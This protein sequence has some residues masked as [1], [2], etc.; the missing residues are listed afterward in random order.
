[1]SKTIFSIDVE[2]SS[3][4]PFKGN[5]LSVGIVAIDFDSLEIGNSEYWELSYPDSAKLDSP[6]TYEWWEQQN[7]HAF[8][9]A[10]GHREC[11]SEPNDVAQKLSDFVCG[12]SDVWDDRIFAAN[13]STFDFGWVSKLLSGAGLNEVFHY[14]T[15]CIRSIAFGIYGGDWGGGRKDSGEWNIPEI[16]HHAYYDALA[17]GKD[18]IKLLQEI[19]T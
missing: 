10:W 9:A 6:M 19:R 2:T 11:R 13:P 3:T 18:L 14:R 17:Q 4:D 7:E 8:E 15:M 1:M 16:P 12:Y 5:L